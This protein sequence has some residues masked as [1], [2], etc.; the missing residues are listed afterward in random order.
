MVGFLE[1]FEKIHRLNPGDRELNPMIYTTKQSPKDNRGRFC[2]DFRDKIVQKLNMI[3]AIWGHGRIIR[4]N[5]EFENLLPSLLMQDPGKEFE[6]FRSS[7]QI[8]ASRDNRERGRLGIYIDR[9]AKS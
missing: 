4:R 1:H 7:L 5:P 3:Q 6:Q 9:E 2:Y 8:S